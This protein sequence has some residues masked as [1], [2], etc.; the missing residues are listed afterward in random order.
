MVYCRPYLPRLY[1]PDELVQAI[2]LGFISLRRNL[3]QANPATTTIFSRY[4]S[5]QFRKLYC[6]YRSVNR[7]RIV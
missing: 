6:A 2:K 4:I 3:E 1:L 5:R 7:T